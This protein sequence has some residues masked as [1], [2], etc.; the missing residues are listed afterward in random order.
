[1]R[2]VFTPKSMSLHQNQYAIQTKATEKRNSQE[3]ICKVNSLCGSQSYPFEKCC[4]IWWKNNEPCVL[5]CITYGREKNLLA[6]EM[7][8]SSFCSNDSNTKN[9]NQPNSQPYHECIYYF[10]QQ[11]LK[12]IRESQN[13]GARKTQREL[14][15]TSLIR[16]LKIAIQRRY[17]K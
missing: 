6:L 8:E 5:N 16:L 3:N 2:V 4:A 10:I 12:S 9:H 17:L 7:L 13:Y 15:A 1:M 14:Y 11:K